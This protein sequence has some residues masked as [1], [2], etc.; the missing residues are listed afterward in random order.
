MQAVQRHQRGPLAYS[1]SRK[2]SFTD[3]LAA[4]CL[5]CQRAPRACRRSS[6]AAILDVQYK[7]ASLAHQLRES[8]AAETVTEMLDGE[9]SRSTALISAATFEP[10]NRKEERV[11]SSPLPRPDREPAASCWW[12]FRQRGGPAHC[13]S[14]SHPAK[15]KAIQTCPRAGWWR[16]KLFADGGPPIGMRWKWISTV[17]AS[18]TAK[19]IC[20]LRQGKHTKLGLKSYFAALRRHG[21]GPATTTYRTGLIC[22][23]IANHARM[24]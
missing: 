22:T 23:S 10:E 1:A 12:P 13:L 19:P 6:S 4:I 2:L 11:D 9:R 17:A 24:A 8:L 5:F 3:L 15:P 16:A 21:R 20:G 14:C 18:T 7:T